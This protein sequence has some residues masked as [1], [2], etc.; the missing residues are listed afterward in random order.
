MSLTFIA[1]AFQVFHSSVEDLLRVYRLRA[2]TEKKL[3]RA[4]GL[5]DT[6]DSGI[7]CI[8]AHVFRVLERMV[9][10]S[11]SLVR[12][13]SRILPPDTD[14][15]VKRQL[16]TAIKVDKRLLKQAAGELNFHVFFVIVS[17]CDPASNSCI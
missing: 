2:V 17:S 12:K 15:A 6:P 13:I 4:E 8:N 7:A 14:A 11:S 9:A 16:P 10:R 5:C 1:C 3:E